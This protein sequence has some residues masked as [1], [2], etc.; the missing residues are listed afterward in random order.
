MPDGV[1]YLDHHSTTPCDPRVV[2]RMLPYFSG[3][4]GNPAALAH[5][6]G[7]EAARAVEQSRHSI[8]SYF[9]VSPRE[10]IFTSGA[11]EANNLAIS[12]F[13]A[14]HPGSHHV[15]TVGIEHRSALEP[16]QMLAARG[17]NVTVLNPDPEGFVSPE[18]LLSALKKE[19]AL[20]SIGIANPDVGTIQPWRDLAA[21]LADRGIAFH[22]DATQA[23]G[24]VDVVTDGPS[25]SSLSLSGHKFYGP[26]GIGALILR[27]GTHLE[28][29]EFGGGQERGLRS[30]TINVP[31]VVG[32]AAALEI[33]QQEMDSEARMLAELRDELLARLES[34]F[35]GLILHGPRSSRLPGNLNVSFPAVTSEDLIETVR[36]FS[37]SS[38]S[39][40]STGT[41]G[42]SPVLTSMGVSEHV[43]MSSIRFGLG[44]MNDRSQLEPLVKELQRAVSR[45][46]E[47]SVG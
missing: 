11:T 3:V 30:G 38:G 40:C 7:N 21:L 24:K 2:D 42:A 28:P 41:R 14:A 9:H 18:L 39:A 35:P 20:V 13:A 26:K 8:A 47:I 36:G 15:V 10:V 33:R 16:C 32:L 46:Q 34:A 12:G 22:T 44:K 19:T 43:A 31:A 45:L 27:S 25:W 6:H 37:L 17:W 4:F 23:V 5:P 1:V 29:I